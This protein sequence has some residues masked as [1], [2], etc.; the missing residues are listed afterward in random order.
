MRETLKAFSWQL[1]IIGP[2]KRDEQI[3]N[4]NDIDSYYAILREIQAMLF[5]KLNAVKA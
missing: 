4:H 3:L 5:H 2:N 1:I